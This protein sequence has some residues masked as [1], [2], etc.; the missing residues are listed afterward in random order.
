MVDENCDRW[1]D[2]DPLKVIADRLLSLVQ[3]REEWWREAVRRWANDPPHYVDDQGFDEGVLPIPFPMRALTAD[4]RLG[5]LAAIC[6]TY[7][8][9]VELIDPWRELRLLTL[10]EICKQGEFDTQTRCRSAADC[11]SS[12]LHASAASAIT[13][14]DLITIPQDGKSIIAKT[15]AGTLARSII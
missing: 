4:E 7:A 8:E 6:D 5:L 14:V 12:N 1:R 10:Q 11:R 2:D 15:D 3:G 13:T 9:G